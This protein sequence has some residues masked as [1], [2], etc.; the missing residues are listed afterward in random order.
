MDI[1]Q[2]QRSR[3]SR[4]QPERLT[5]SIAAWFMLLVTT[6]LAQDAIPW[7]TGMALRKQLDAS[8]G[9]TWPE[10]PLREG[11]ASLSR[12]TGVCVFLDRRVDPDQNIE[13]TVRDESLQRVLEQLAEK[14]HAR[15]V[16]V[17]P[18]LYRGPP[19]AAGQLGALA[20]LR[21]KQAAALPN[22]TKARLLKSQAWKWDELAEPRA[23]LDGLTRQA[24]VT[25]LNPDLLPHDLWPA[26]DLP[27]LAW[28]DRLTLL[29]A[30]FGL[31]YE[32]ADEG[33]A[34][35]LVPMPE[36]VLVEKTYTPRGEPGPV[37]AQLRRIVPRAKIRV[38]GG[39]LLVTAA[40]DDQDKVQRLLSGETVKTTTPMPGEKR[41]S[42][43]VTN[44][45]V[46]SVVKTVANQLGKEMKFDPQIVER[47]QTKVSLVVKDV[48]LDE[49]LSKAL[50]PL[51]L[52]YRIDDRAIEITPV[53]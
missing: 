33:T 34:I 9:V 49:L 2:A 26:A 42:L 52:G 22:A 29:L 8:V 12:S 46:G 30:G 39:K 48:T 20:A 35:R 10:R 3:L 18:V 15:V 45:A 17:G 47:L 38:E 4:L 53:E 40:E 6:G 14:T 24:G 43:T 37:V 25:T 44:Q 16:T 11:L 13:L 1:R 21:H 51:K 31:T 7:K 32:F 41:Y 19:Q 5:W 28:V 27:P 50:A 23:L 36:E